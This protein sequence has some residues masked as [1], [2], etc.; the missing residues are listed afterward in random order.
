MINAILFNHLCEYAGS[1][2]SNARVDSGKNGVFRRAF[3]ESR[4]PGPDMVVYGIDIPRRIP[5]RGFIFSNARLV[6]ALR[7]DAGRGVQ[8][9]AIERF[10]S[11]CGGG[12]EDAVDAGG[13]V[14]E[15]EEAFGPGFA[16][17]ADFGGGEVV[18]GEVAGCV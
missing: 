13:L 7:L 3:T 2:V 17:G 11:G 14:D 15:L 1:V 10:A 4:G 5:A 6:R 16:G 18:V 8:R 12:H 9:S